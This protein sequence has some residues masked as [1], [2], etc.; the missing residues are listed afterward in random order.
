RHVDLLPVL[1]DERNR[2]S[3]PT[4]WLI[5]VC[6]G[7]VQTDRTM[8]GPVADRR[9]AGGHVAAARRRGSFRPGSQPRGDAPRKMPSDWAARGLTG[10]R[11]APGHAGELRQA[12]RRQPGSDP[13]AHHAERRAD[14]GAWAE[15]ADRRRGG[16]REIGPTMRV[17]ALRPYHP[18][19]RSI[20]Q[21]AVLP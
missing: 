6:P 8:Y 19:A 5:G 1:A 7:G 17:F 14:P 21:P 20:Y 4:P 11:R 10:Q 12:S 18:S 3:W 2:P 13:Q 16:G 15:E 9:R